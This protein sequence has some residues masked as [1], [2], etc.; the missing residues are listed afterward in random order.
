MI[1]VGEIGEVVSVKS[2]TRGPSK[3]KNGCMIFQS[4]MGHLGKF[5]VMILIQFDGF[6]VLLV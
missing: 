6:L 5:A 3:Q 4:V 2:H 1:E